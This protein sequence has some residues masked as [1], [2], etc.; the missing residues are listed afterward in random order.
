M[1]IYRITEAPAFSLCHLARSVPGLLLFPPPHNGDHAPYDETR[2]DHALA[3]QNEP[4]VGKGQLT[5][6]GAVDDAVHGVG[7]YRGI[8]DVLNSLTGKVLGGGLS[9]KENLIC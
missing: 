7:V 5:H 4:V 2:G 3:D 6:R 8:Q 1:R 9:T